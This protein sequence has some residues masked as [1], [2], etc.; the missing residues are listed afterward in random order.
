MRPQTC[1]AT[2]PD[3]TPESL[4]PN[5]S[6]AT[7]NT[8]RVSA[9][10]SGVTEKPLPKG[11]GQ[12]LKCLPSLAWRAA[13]SHAVTTWQET[14]WWRLGHKQSPRWRLTG[15]WGRLAPTLGSLRCRTPW[16]LLHPLCCPLSG[17][18]LLSSCSPRV[19]LQF[20]LACALAG[21]SSSLRPEAREAVLSTCP[22]GLR[23]Q[24]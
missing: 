21:S 4:R 15:H 6:R 3:P 7:P 20:F 5:G 8:I 14:P 2:P 23:N 13:A 18:T 11:T 16:L 24:D 17:P 10:R 1:W 9:D 12:L 19:L 22:G